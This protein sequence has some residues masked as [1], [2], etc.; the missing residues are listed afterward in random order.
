VLDFSVHEQHL[1]FF[2]WPFNEV[3]FLVVKNGQNLQLGF[4]YQWIF[5]FNI[6]I[7]LLDDLDII[8]NDQF[9]YSNL[10]HLTGH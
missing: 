4:C 9:F 8:P 3:V 6:L 10:I 5:N 7:F 2:D 1:K